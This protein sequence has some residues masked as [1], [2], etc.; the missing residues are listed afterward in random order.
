MILVKPSATIIS[1]SPDAL[2]LIE[3]AG[4]TCYKSEETH[5]VQ[6]YKLASDPEFQ[7]QFDDQVPSGDHIEGTLKS[8][9]ETHVT[10]RFV[11]GIIKRGHESVIEHASATV[12]FIC[13]RGVSHEL[14]RHRLAGF[15]QES[16]RYVNYGDRGC[17]FVIPPWTPWGEGEYE[18]KDGN[19][20]HNGREIDPHRYEYDNASPGSSNWILSMADAEARYNE[21][22]FLK[23][24]PQQARSVLPN[25]TKTEV[26]MTANLREW[27]H[28]LKLRTSAKA[29][30][31]MVEV[32]TPLLNAMHKMMPIVFG[33]ILSG[34]MGEGQ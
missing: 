8:Y 17:R 18:H 11:G 25:S 31:Q 20:L 14:V 28:V 27:R 30:P 5:D 24:S 4:R 22:L 7:R 9:A 12:R 26:V 29:H 15:S 19:F 34:A 2:R 10:S 16:T 33:D 13:D 1:C 32:M 23:W 21:L 6:V 3:D